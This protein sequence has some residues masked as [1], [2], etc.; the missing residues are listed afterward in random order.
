MWIYFKCEYIHIQVFISCHRFVDVAQN[1]AQLFLIE[2]NILRSNLDESYNRKHVVCEYIIIIV[3][4]I[5]IIIII[6]IMY[7]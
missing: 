6:I 5:V 2:E 7:C 4:I 1:S 3:V